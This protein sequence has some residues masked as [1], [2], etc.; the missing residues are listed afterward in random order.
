M[1]TNPVSSC[2]SWRWISSNSSNKTNWYAFFRIWMFLQQINI[3]DDSHYI[4]F[5]QKCSENYIQSFSV[6]AAHGMEYLADLNIVHRDL[7]ARNCMQVLF[8]CSDAFSNQLPK[9][10][11]YSLCFRLNKNLVLKISDFGLSRDMQTKEYY[12]VENTSVELPV[13]WMSPESLTNWTFTTKSDVVRNILISS[14]MRAW[15]SISV[16]L[17]IQWREKFLAL[18]WWKIF[19]ERKFF[20][21]CWQCNFCWIW[22]FI[23]RLYCSW[24]SP[25]SWSTLQFHSSM[26]FGTKKQSKCVFYL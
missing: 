26:C 18:F 16:S 14:F 6:G 2:L 22:Y 10:T 21:P 20:L 25:I 1:K 12:K 17:G 13:R 19:D 4:I 8:C 11:V 23:E 15:W 24:C 3:I 7:A 9:T 5:L